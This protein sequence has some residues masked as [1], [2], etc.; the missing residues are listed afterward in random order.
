[1]PGLTEGAS[2]AA[3]IAHGCQPGALAHPKIAH[4]EE[5]PLCVLCDV[6]GEAQLQ[7]CSIKVAVG[8]GLSAQD[9]FPRMKYGKDDKVGKVPASR[10]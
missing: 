4:A 8:K 2:E 10:M 6:Q 3:A 5:V 9:E 1:M 7:V